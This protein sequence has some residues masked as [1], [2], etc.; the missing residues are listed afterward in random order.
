[1]VLR[2][3]GLASA[4]SICRG[5]SDSCF[6]CRRTFLRETLRTINTFPIGDKQ[7]AQDNFKGCNDRK[8]QRQANAQFAP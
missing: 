6:R 1:M 5:C 3:V 2:A 4:A 8:D 7:K